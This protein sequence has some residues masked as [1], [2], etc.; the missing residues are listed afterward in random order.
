[1]IVIDAIDNSIVESLSWAKYLGCTAGLPHDIS[2]RIYL[3]EG[4]P[5]QFA[6]PRGESPKTFM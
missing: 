4:L 5:V 1:M 3:F 6:R 2:Q